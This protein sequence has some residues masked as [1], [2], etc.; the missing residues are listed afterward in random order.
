DALS[1]LIA[2]CSVA[3]ASLGFLIA[4]GISVEGDLFWISA[5]LALYAGG[6][7][8]FAWRR[9]LVGFSWAAAV[10]LLGASAQTCNSLLALRFSW[11]ASFLF[12][13]LMCVAGAVAARRFTRPETA[14]LFVPPLKAGAIIGSG[15][16]ALLLIAQLIWF[17][18]EPASVFATRAGI[19]SIV[20]LGLLS[21]GGSAFFFAGFQ[22]ALALAAVLLTKSIL[23][24]FDWYGFQPDA[25]ADPRALQ[26]QGIVLGLMCLGWVA[27]RVVLRK[28]RTDAND[29]GRVTPVIVD[30]RVAFDHVLAIALVFV[31]AIIILY[32]SATGVA[33]ELTNPARVAR[34]YDFAG[35]AH[36]L[37]FGVGSLI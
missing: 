24:R 23:Q 37:T 34:I 36:A 31:F 4:F 32:G 14:R 17:G 21:L 16:A 18:C 27:I 35:H 11:Q 25:W 22:I 30:G 13:A 10:L 6:A 26:V 7:F 33:Y 15:A 20:F 29:R 19:L 5:I 28:V 3:I 1:Y 2:A 8:W 12:F 9:K